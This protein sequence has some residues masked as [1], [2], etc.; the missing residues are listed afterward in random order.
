MKVNIHTEAPSDISTPVIVRKE[1]GLH[2]CLYSEVQ[3]QPYLLEWELSEALKDHIIHT[4][5]NRIAIIE[6]KKL[7]VI[8]ISSGWCVCND[9]GID[10]FDTSFD[11][12]REAVDA[13]ID[14]HNNQ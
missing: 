9:E 7:E 1:F 14:Q 2:F 8:H 11:T 4:D 5:E 10:L 3:G 13:V 12:W 6:K